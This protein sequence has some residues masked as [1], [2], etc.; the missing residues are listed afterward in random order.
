MLMKCYI[1][2]LICL[3]TA[4]SIVS[5][6]LTELTPEQIQ[7]ELKNPEKLRTRC[8]GV[9]ADT[10]E[11]LSRIQSDK[12]MMLLNQIWFKDGSFVLGLSRNDAMDLGIPVEMYDRFL[13]YVNKA[14]EYIK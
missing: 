10:L 8:P 6:T 9:P 5:C 14:N 2:G 11:M 12:E 3:S 13:N 1:K 4:F 7:N